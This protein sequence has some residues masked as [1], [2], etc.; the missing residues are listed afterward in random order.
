MAAKTYS[1]NTAG[2]KAINK[3]LNGLQ[4]EIPGATASALNRT[5]DHAVTV[6]GKEVSEEYAI[7]SAKAKST[8]RKYKASK[9]LLRAYMS[10]KGS[11]LTLGSFP[12]KPETTII[13]RTLGVKHKSSQ[14]RVKIKRGDTLRTLNVTPKA[15]LQKSN[16]ATNIFQRE[17]KSRFPIRVLRTLSIPQMVGQEKTMLNIQSQTSKKLGERITHEINFRIKKAAEKVK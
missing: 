10:S 6:A 17:G 9:S 14:V 2:L 7:T 15:F 5:L 12:H 8:I 16:G 1:I 3:Q 13:A 4:K 11:T